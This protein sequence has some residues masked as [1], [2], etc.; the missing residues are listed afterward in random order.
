MSS[1]AKKLFSTGDSSSDNDDDDDDEQ[2]QHY[3]AI[4]SR[5]VWK[6]DG[7]SS[8]E[9]DNDD[10]LEN[11]DDDNDNDDAVTVNIIYHLAL[12]ARGHG[13]CVWNAGGCLAEYLLFHRDRLLPSTYT[14]WPPHRTLEF[15]AGAALPSLVLMRDALLNNFNINI[16]ITDSGKNDAATFAALERSVEENGRNWNVL[17]DDHHRP[18]LDPLEERAN[19]HPVMI[20]ARHTWGIDIDEFQIRQDCRDNVQLLL[21]ADCIYNPQCHVALLDSANAFIDESNG[22]FIVA[23]SFHSN[24]SDDAVLHFFTI[25]TTHPYQFH[26]VQ[27]LQHDYPQGQVGIGGTDPARG[28]VYIK[29][30]A[31]RSSTSLFVS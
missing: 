27:E 12:T 14:I 24:V 5:H 13:D 9:Y 11:H 26:I 7:S 2:Q 6:C 22:L 15:G 19:D 10:S 25:A 20:I 29:V 8:L 1:A 18:P 28:A 30:L 16:I 3:E 23:Y 21:A 4:I 17:P 31:K